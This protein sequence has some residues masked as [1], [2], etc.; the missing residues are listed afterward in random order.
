MKHP[1][2]G[3]S[4]HTSQH[5]DCGGVIPRGPAAP[6]P[7]AP[8]T[9]RNSLTVGLPHSPGVSASGAFPA[10]LTRFLDTLGIADEPIWRGPKDGE[11]PF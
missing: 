9:V 5:A 7:S 3:V 6:I 8:G 11:C 2:D 10:S 1:H 4:S